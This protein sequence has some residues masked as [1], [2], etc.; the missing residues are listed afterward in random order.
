ME[1][2]T[3][4]LGAI[5]G[6]LAVVVLG[7]FVANIVI[8]TSWKPYENGGEEIDEFAKMTP[9]KG[10]TPED[11]ISTFPASYREDMTN[12]EKRAVL[13]NEIASLK[14]KSPERGSEECE[15][16]IRYWVYA[17]NYTEEP[18]E[19]LSEDEISMCLGGADTDSEQNNTEEANEAE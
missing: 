4:V 12:E 1:K 18:G 3:K 5:L 16:M 6:I 17:N 14:S 7:L 13:I 9:M 15:T 19:Q 10:E 8:V 2:E 11:D